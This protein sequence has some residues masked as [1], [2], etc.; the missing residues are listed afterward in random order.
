MAATLCELARTTTRTWMT[1]RPARWPAGNQLGASMVLV[2]QQS[3]T[4]HTTR[5]CRA[6][7]TSVYGP[8]LNTYCTVIDGPAAERISNHG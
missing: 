7:D 3:C 5:V 6:S 1:R 4:G 2:G 8:P